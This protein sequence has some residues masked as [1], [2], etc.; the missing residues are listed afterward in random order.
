M[1]R[2]KTPKFK[3]LN[4]RKKYSGTKKSPFAGNCFVCSKKATEL[5]TAGIRVNC[6]LCLCLQGKTAQ[7]IK[8]QFPNR[9]IEYAKGCIW[10]LGRFW[11]AACS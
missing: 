7:K 4:L 6:S 5:Q 10:L 9:E 1:P 2:G 3:V 11:V 8:S